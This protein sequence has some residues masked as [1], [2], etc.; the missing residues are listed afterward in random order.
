MRTQSTYININLSCQHGELPEVYEVLSSNMAGKSSNG[1]SYQHP[2]KAD[3]SSAGYHLQTH[4]DHLE[5]ESS[6][7]L[8]HFVKIYPNPIPIILLTSQWV[9][10]VFA[11][12]LSPFYLNYSNYSMDPQM[13]IPIIS[14]FSSKP[15]LS[16]VSLE[17][18]RDFPMIFPLKPSFLLGIPYKKRPITPCLCLRHH[19]W[20]VLT[21]R[22]LGHR[23]TKV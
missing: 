5:L 7:N 21:Q 12:K 23:G 19:H 8:G 17:I 6:I 11:D 22:L 16:V 20:R 14:P 9:V 3:K 18:F 10:I 4:L 1:Q 15:V 13:F 2:A